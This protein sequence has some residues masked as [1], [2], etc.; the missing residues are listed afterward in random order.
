[1]E[2]LTPPLI[3]IISAVFAA[4]GAYGATRLELAHLWRELRRVTD[5]IERAHQRIDTIFAESKVRDF[6]G[7]RR[8]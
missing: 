8:F 2:W 7:K 3:A 4:G 1:M 6:Y 5:D